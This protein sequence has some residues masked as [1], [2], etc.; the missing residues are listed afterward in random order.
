MTSRQEVGKIPGGFFGKLAAP[1]AVRMIQ[2]DV[3]VSLEKL[4]ELL[5]AEH[6]RW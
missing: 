2:K 4:K 3:R 6:C 1:M 5:K